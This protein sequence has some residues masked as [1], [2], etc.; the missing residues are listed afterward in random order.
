VRVAQSPKT[1]GNYTVSPAAYPRWRRE[2]R[3]F[4]DFDASVGSVFVL[5]QDGSV[6]ALR[7]ARVTANYFNISRTR[8]ATACDR[9]A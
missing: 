2:V 6:E 1:G 7:G 3:S 4:T 9:M 8:E 5:V